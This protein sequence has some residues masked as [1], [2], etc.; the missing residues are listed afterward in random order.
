MHSI[1]STV[2]TGAIFLVWFVGAVENPAL[3][4]AQE[5][6]PVTT[7]LLIRHA[8]KAGNADDSPLAHSGKARAE[9]LVQVA[10]WAGVKAVYSTTA[11]RALATADPLA[12]CV[13]LKPI[14]YENVKNLVNELVS[15]H[16]GQVVLVVSHSGW[17]Q[18][19]IDALAG[20]GS[21]APTDSEYDSFHVLTLYAPGKAS[22]LRLKYGETVTPVPCASPQ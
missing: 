16:P 3:V 22:L 5:A 4:A 1:R 2:I 21:S 6:H 11:V 15:K 17:I 13:G 14:I 8:E 20:P 18:Q 9:K 12:E 7:I 19:V 10:G